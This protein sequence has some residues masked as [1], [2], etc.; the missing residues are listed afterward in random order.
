VNRFRGG[1]VQDQHVE[2]ALQE[3]G[4]FAWWHGDT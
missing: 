1:D 3:I 4:G 2:R